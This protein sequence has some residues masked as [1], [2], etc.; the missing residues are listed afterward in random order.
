MGHLHAHRFGDHQ[1]CTGE[2]AIFDNGGNIR[3][4]KAAFRLA[5]RFAGFCRK[6]CG[7]RSKGYGATGPGSLSR[8]SLAFR[9]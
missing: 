5:F 6:M 3:D 2:W 9:P 8:H 4:A 7:T 1:T